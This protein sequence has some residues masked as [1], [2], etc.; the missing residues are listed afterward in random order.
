MKKTTIIAVSMAVLATML[1]SAQAWNGRGPGMTGDQ[2]GMHGGFGPMH[3]G[4]GGFAAG[5]LEEET[6]SGRIQ[7]QEGELPSITSGG[8]TYSLHIP[9]VLTEELAMS[10]GQQITV[11]GYVTSVQSF[12]LVNEETILR[13]RAVESDGTRVVLPTGTGGRPG[14]QGDFS[15]RRTPFHGGRR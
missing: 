10:D 11:E 4:Q 5:D 14:S 2:T 15:S 12:D 6:V 3:S 13:V 8:T 7:L 9:W 1:V